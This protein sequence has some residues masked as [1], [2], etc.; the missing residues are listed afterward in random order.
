[1]R[2]WYYTETNNECVLYILINWT[3]TVCSLIYE[4]KS[5]KTSVQQISVYGSKHFDHTMTT[6]NKDPLSVVFLLSRCATVFAYR[7]CCLCCCYSNANSTGV[8]K[9]DTPSI[10]TGSRTSHGCLSNLERFRSRIVS[11]RAV[12]GAVN[13]NRCGFVVLRAYHAHAFGVVARITTWIAVV[14]IYTL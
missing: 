3:T 7:L 11:S 9:R 2:Y 10:Y 1:M 8:I 14:G 12:S 5:N 13:A 4:L 6:P